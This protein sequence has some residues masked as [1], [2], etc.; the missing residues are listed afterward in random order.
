MVHY[1]HISM[2]YCMFTG[3]REL[4]YS[5]YIGIG[6]R[7]GCQ[8]FLLQNLQVSGVVTKSRAQSKP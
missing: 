2:E 8:H 1:K 3:N 5:T 6:K 4:F 7:G